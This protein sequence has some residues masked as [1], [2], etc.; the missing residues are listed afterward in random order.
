LSSTTKAKRIR[1]IKRR[2][3]PELVEAMHKRQIS[4]RVADTLLYLPPQEQLAQL[5]RRL[6]FAQQRENKSK[7]IAQTIRTY[8]D[9]HQQVDLEELRLLIEGALAHA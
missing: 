8:L 4:V 5:E 9:D 3:I 1:R 2:A 7:A 6:R